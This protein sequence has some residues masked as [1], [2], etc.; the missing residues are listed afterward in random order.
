[1]K[2]II[3]AFAALFV[4]VYGFAQITIYGKAIN[5]IVVG[6]EYI[7]PDTI[8]YVY[9]Q[10]SYEAV[11]F[12]TF[13]QQC[14]SWW[15]DD[16]L[17]FIQ[18]MKDGAAISEDNP[19]EDFGWAADRLVVPNE[20]YKTF[21]EQNGL[22][23]L[24]PLSVIGV[25]SI[26]W[27]PIKANEDFYLAEQ[28]TIPLGDVYGN[29]GEART[30]CHTYTVGPEPAYANMEGV[31]V[32]MSNDTIASYDVVLATYNKMLWSGA[33]GRMT[34]NVYPLNIGS[35]TMTVTMN[36][37]SKSMHIT[38]V[39]ADTIH[40]EMTLTVEQLYQKIYSRLTDTGD[41]HPDGMPDISA[42]DEGITG[43][44]RLLSDVN[45][46]PS[47]QIWWIWNDP[48][49]G[50]L[51]RVDWDAD[52]DLL[53]GL[54][55]RLYYNVWLCNSY[56]NRAETTQYETE[57]AEVQL[58]RAYHYY[59]LMDLFGNVPIVTE[60][61][62]MKSAQQRTRAELYNF[63]VSELL[64]AEQGLPAHRVSQY[65]V[66]KTAAQ[67]LLSR[68]YL[69]AEVYAGTADYDNAT[70]YAKKVIDSDYSLVSQYKY[71]FMGDNDSNGAE[72]EIIWGLQQVGSERSTWSGSAYI[73]ASLYDVGMPWWGTTDGWR[74]IRSQPELVK[75]FFP[76]GTQIQGTDSVLTI[77]ANDNRALFCNYY[78]PYEGRVFVWDLIGS[79]GF[80]YEDFYK[81]WAITK[82]NN[83][84]TN[85]TQ[86]D[87]RFPDTD[88]PLLRKAEAYLNY[89]EAVLRGGEVRDG[90]EAVTAFNVVRARANASAY[91]SL[92]LQDLLDERGREFYMENIRR[93][94]LIRFGKFTGSGIERDGVLWD[95]ESF[96]TLYPIPNAILDLN[97]SIKQNAGY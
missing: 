64:A 56:L 27:H 3:L 32:I 86:T 30:Y 83:L 61:T 73:V 40:D 15:S 80:G 82:W 10:L 51:V 6:D 1:M 11:D 48:G 76:N 29:S 55:R 14:P 23:V 77:A 25:D 85:G 28:D 36:G 84:R 57:R 19:V 90:Y 44:Q 75:L 22:S 71:L 9:G 62:Q 41:M 39:P 88:I 16:G 74:C 5:N 54:F 96:R 31:T 4:S 34:I 20:N 26:V 67:L 42:V 60:N 94:D 97:P 8:P 91:S 7:E 87:S 68:V 18:L 12:M 43:L 13:S 17:T 65:R 37:V 33:Q 45:D 78:V 93:P 53:H 72:A 2:K 66:D 79:G 89:A 52:N 47:D 92:L 50:D 63:V 24:G 21:V 69:N 38:V 58:I 49:V 95:I 35:T 59:L 81:S 46:F 70:L